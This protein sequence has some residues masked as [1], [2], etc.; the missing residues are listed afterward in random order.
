MATGDLETGL[1]RVTDLLPAGI[2]QPSA[3]KVVKPQS[4]NREVIHFDSQKRTGYFVQ[5]GKV[6]LSD[7][8]KAVEVDASGKLKERIERLC[9]VRDAARKLLQ[10]QLQSDE[11]GVLVPYRLALT[12]AYDKLVK[13]CGP[14]SN[15]ANR[16]AFRDDPDLPLVL[17]LEHWDEETQTATKAEI[18]EKRT[19]R[20]YRKVE[21]CSS[22]FRFHNADQHRARV[23]PAHRVT[24]QEERPINQPGNTGMHISTRR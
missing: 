13:T 20:A 2:Y 18:F 11:D 14:I 5:S 22:V 8:A 24:T 3:K 4:R 15:S 19:I 10:A 1:A 12:I 9:E 17:S 21:A 23:N 6:F 7:G 16:R